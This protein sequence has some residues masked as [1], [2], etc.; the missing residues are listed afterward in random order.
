MYSSA[1]SGEQAFGFIFLSCRDSHHCAVVNPPP[2]MAGS[3]IPTLN[4]SHGANEVLVT[5][6]EPSE[7]APQVDRG[8]QPANESS[9][10]KKK[11]TVSFESDESIPG[12]GLMA[13]A[14]RAG[15]GEEFF[16]IN[17]GANMKGW[18]AD[19]ADHR[20]HLPLCLD[21]PVQWLNECLS[22]ADWKDLRQH[23]HIR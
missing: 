7:F 15:Y 21:L 18:L 2:N 22:K 20:R 1:V 17:L 12:E 19:V 16:N 23:G 3:L 10:R 6:V 5:S 4:Q 8:K 14:R 11:R 13:D 9:Q